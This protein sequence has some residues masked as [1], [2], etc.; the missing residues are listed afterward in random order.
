MKT[1]S[2]GSLIRGRPLA[3]Q[4]PLA[5]GPSQRMRML[6]RGAFHLMKQAARRIRWAETSSAAPTELDE[7]IGCGCYKQVAPT[8]L[9]SGAT[10]PQAEPAA[11]GARHVYRVRSRTC[12]SAPVGRHVEESRN[13]EGVRKRRQAARAPNASR[14]P[15]GFGMPA[16]HRCD[17]GRSK[18]ACQPEAHRA[19]SAVRKLT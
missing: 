3:N 11:P 13:F 9:P 1:I 5:A 8:E 17:Y 4:F 7:R 15:S 10:W 12:L 16:R 14:D 6:V 18:A 2:M 19:D